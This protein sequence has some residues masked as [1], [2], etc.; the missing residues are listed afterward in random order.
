MTLLNG[1]PTESYRIKRTFSMVTVVSLTSFK[2]CNV[3][4]FFLLVAY[5]LHLCKDLHVEFHEPETSLK[6]N[7]TKKIKKLKVYNLRNV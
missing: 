6:E 1:S 2:L 3:L 4:T 5:G 7:N